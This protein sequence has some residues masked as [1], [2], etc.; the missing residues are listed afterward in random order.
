MAIDPRILAMPGRSTP[1]RQT[2]LGGWGWEDLQK[3]A[4]QPTERCALRH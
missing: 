4:D 3:N 2:L 1:T